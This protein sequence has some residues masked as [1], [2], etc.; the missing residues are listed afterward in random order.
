[1]YSEDETVNLAF[2][3]SCSFCKCN[4]I[5]VRAAD[6]GLLLSIECSSTLR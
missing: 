4:I 6:P 5:G 1:L 3:P 2:S